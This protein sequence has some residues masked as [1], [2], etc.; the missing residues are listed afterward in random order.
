MAEKRREKIFLVLGALVLSSCAQDTQN[1]VLSDTLVITPDSCT[2]TATPLSPTENTDKIVFAFHKFGTASTAPGASI[3]TYDQQ[4]NV[5]SRVFINVENQQ[6]TIIQENSAPVVVEDESQRNANV[7]EATLL[8]QL[9]GPKKLI[10]PDK[11]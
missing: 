4:D 8:H 5:I 9:C 6:Q 11:G 3:T 7:R 1:Y 10:A 2:L